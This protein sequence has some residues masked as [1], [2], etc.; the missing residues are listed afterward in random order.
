MTRNVNGSGAKGNA[1]PYSVAGTRLQEAVTLWQANEQSACGSAVNACAA[2]ARSRKRLADYLEELGDASA[3][4]EVR[5]E[6][7]EFAQRFKLPVWS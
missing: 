1:P 3:A 7:D 5:G 6:V 4:A 2:T